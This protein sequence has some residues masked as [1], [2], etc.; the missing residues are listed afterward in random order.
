MSLGPDAELAGEALG[1]L[2]D[3][4]VHC[5]FCLPACPTYVVVGNEMDSPRGR[6]HLMGQMAGETP[7]KAP[8]SRPMSQSIA[9]HLDL[10]LGCMACVSACPSGVRYDRLIEAARVEVEHSGLRSRRQALL[11][12]LVFGLFCHP[13]R[14]TALRPLL[15]AYDRLG[16]GRALRSSG[17]LERLPAPLRAMEELLA[18]TPPFSRLAGLPPRTPAA[19]ERR[20]TAA[21]L[22]GCVQRVF[23]GDVN[24]ASARV[25]S[26][27]GVEVLAPRQG[28][29]GALS[30]HAGRGDE[31]R[32]FARA[33]MT[34]LGPGAA[35]VPDAH[36]IDYVVATSAG[37][38]SA[39]KSYGEI[40]A[41]DPAW[42]ERAAAFS[43]RVRDVAELL[44]EIGPA[45][46][47]HPLSVRAAY[48]DACHLSHAQGIRSAPRR[49]L[50]AIPG[51]ELVEVADPELCCG[52]AGTYNIFEPELAGA[53]GDRKAGGVA[54][55]GAEV[56]V[57]GNP[58]CLMQIGAALRRLGVEIRLAHTIE[59]LDAS[60]NPP[61]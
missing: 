19:G 2:L 47:R 56:V 57:A 18:A 29:C 43:A 50:G 20:A 23:F 14:I 61:G 17:A 27:D 7:P 26:A 1:E 44:D 25:L 49:L 41:R 51:L 15:R 9:R 42:R 40:F 16:F 13:R 3:D 33:L 10:C 6:I 60:I 31:F 30:L 54:R 45:A 34:A 53:L 28:C 35:N 36:R 55:S 8:R 52:S 11:R 4:C 21:L 48:H 12:A 46:E 37:C 39:M 32:R 38:G 58:G 22:L 5:G 59:L 24:L